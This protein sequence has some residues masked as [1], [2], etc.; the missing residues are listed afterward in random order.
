LLAF[1]GIVVG[2]EA[3]STTAVVTRNSAAVLRML[4]NY[5]DLT[6]GQLAELT[7]G[8]VSRSAVQSYAS[9][10]YP[11]PIDKVV[12]LAQALRAKPELFFGTPDDALRWML[13]NSPNGELEEVPARSRRYA[14]PE[15]VKV[16]GT[17]SKQR[18]HAS[19]YKHEYKTALTVG[20]VK[21]A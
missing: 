3:L 12:I 11:I 10:R 1:W 9:G 7:D 5:R 20:G 15:P 18:K 16:G 14:P 21:A 6:D 17:P 13:D 2:M 4:R 19:S 8:A